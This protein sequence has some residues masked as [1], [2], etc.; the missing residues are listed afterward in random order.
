MGAPEPQGSASRV[1]GASRPQQKSRPGS[2][3]TFPWGGG[4]EGWTGRARP[5]F[6][7]PSTGGRSQVAGSSES[8]FPDCDVTGQA[9]T[10]VLPTGMC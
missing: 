2:L 6:T 9:Q 7:S 3:P 4:A 1:L 5:G 10:R 8:V